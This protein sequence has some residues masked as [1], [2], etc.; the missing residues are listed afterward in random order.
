[1]GPEIISAWLQD[2]DVDADV[3]VDNK[4]N[5]SPDFC[6]LSSLTKPIF[7]SQTPPKMAR[8]SPR[9][10][11]TSA[12]NSDDLDEDIRH[13]SDDVFDTPRPSRR[14]AFAQIL[15][16]PPT[17][18][19]ITSARSLTRS[20]NSNSR[21]T[22]SGT[23]STNS[24]TRSRSPIKGVDDLL[25]LEKPVQWSTVDMVDL[26]VRMQNSMPSG[27]ACPDLLVSLVGRLN[28]KYIP[29]EIREILS[30][31][32]PVESTLDFLFTDTETILPSLS[33]PVTQFLTQ[34]LGTGSGE[35]ATQLMRR[36]ALLTE[37]SNIQ[38][39][40]AKT[41][42][43]N[44]PSRS[45]AAWN[46]NVY[47]PMLDLAV[48]HASNIAVE[49]IT[50]A[51]IVEKFVPKSAA[52]YNSEFQVKMID[53]ALALR[54]E[55]GFHERLLEFVS[56]L[57]HPT[58]NQTNYHPLRT[59]PAGIFIGTKARDHGQCITETKI[60]LGI[61]VASWFSRVARFP[62]NTSASTIS[63]KLPYVPILLVDRGTWE[64]YFAFDG[65]SNWFAGSS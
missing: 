27:N 19:S 7:P 22:N 30:Q 46:E 56:H 60:Q 17:L 14:A 2:V 49:N 1:M 57:D 10:K 37:Y 61:W 11:P 8:R 43:F 50:R 38:S 40:V 33:Q 25:R 62:R 47:G 54:P 39:I 4:A 23:R 55:P 3:D 59:S 45:E 16:N 52:T 21:S 24:G 36:F 58:F 9:K 18:P 44:T 63:S 13:P 28:S 34:P 42:K 29:C 35:T 48:L 65:Q 15:Q 12:C 5:S 26:Q 64:L 53:Y 31:V 6:Y 41:N 32:S 51:N 20:T